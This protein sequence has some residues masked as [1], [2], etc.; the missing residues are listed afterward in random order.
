MK[1]Q[2]PYHCNLYEY[3]SVQK[4][5][6]QKKKKIQGVIQY[7]H[8]VREEPQGWS[9]YHCTGKTVPKHKFSVLITVFVNSYHLCWRRHRGDLVS[10]Y[11]NYLKIERYRSWLNRLLG[12]EL[13]QDN[14]NLLSWSLDRSLLP[15][16]LKHYKELC[17]GRE[18]NHLR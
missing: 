13:S 17:T 14:Q 8:N 10:L 6:I 9:P 2:C 12:L 5:K 1:K 7:L 16:A 3:Q 11:C 15:S 18:I 4:Y